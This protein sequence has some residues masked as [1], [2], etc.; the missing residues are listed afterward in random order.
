M[1]IEPAQ[2]VDELAPHNA[3][4]ALA[5]VAVAASASAVEQNAFPSEAASAAASENADSAEAG[6][7]SVT[8]HYNEIVFYEDPD[9]ENIGDLR[10]LKTK[11]F[12][13]LTPGQTINPWNYVE[14]IDGYFLYD[15]WAENPKASEDS[16]QN[17]V[18]LNYMAT[19]NNSISINYYLLSDGLSNSAT[20]PLP[21]D[22][23]ALDESEAEKGVLENPGMRG[24]VVVDY[25]GEPVRVTKL[26]DVEVDGQRFNSV[27]T[28]S[29]CAVPIDHMMFLDSYPSSFR[30]TTNP[31]NNSIDL[32]YAP[33]MTTLPDATPVPDDT[34]TEPDEPSSPE[35]PTNPDNGTNEGGDGTEGDAP[36]NPDDGTTSDKPANP[37]QPS[38]TEPPQDG[39]ND[40]NESSGTDSSNPDTGN[41]SSS[42]AGN[43]DKQPDNSDNGE[44]GDADTG[45]GSADNSSA[46]TEDATENSGQQNDA[47]S[48]SSGSTLTPTGDTFGPIVLVIA[49]AAAL[50]L[51]VA[52]V[53]RRR[54]S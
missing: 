51:G 41:D 31:E 28:G 43:D 6:T 52:I 49:L 4:Q 44:A 19:S 15:G 32:F 13:G 50:S 48:E 10:L 18:Q 46:G 27:I 11:V 1:A 2:L 39:T 25:Y 26:G 9:V 29:E 45:T 40:G 16:S 21:N 47:N 7:C 22:S 38:G 23:L 42:S 35:G 54:L 36:S 30:V 8:V 33:T 5:D 53:V 12:D 20:A 17:V 34:T 3:A 14:P 37:D 24:S